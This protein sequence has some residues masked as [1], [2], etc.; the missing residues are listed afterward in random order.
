MQQ[1]EEYGLNMQS[2]PIKVKM[3]SNHIF[4]MILDNVLKENGINGTIGFIAEKIYED[5][6]N[7]ARL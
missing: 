1:L 4:D 2:K 6:F 3:T 7:C 5:A